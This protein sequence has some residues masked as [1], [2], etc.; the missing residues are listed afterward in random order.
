MKADI[1]KNQI[2]SSYM[3]ILS[4]TQPNYKLVQ[5]QPGQKDALYGMDS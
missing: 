2:S 3:E 4:K 1:H 5:S